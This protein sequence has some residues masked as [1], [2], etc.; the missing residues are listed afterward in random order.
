MKAL[1][2]SKTDMLTIQD[3]LIE[4]MKN[5]FVSSFLEA[6]LIYTESNF[7]ARLLKDSNFDECHKK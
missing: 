1:D 4:A 2:Y 7:T 3:K 5:A 6:K